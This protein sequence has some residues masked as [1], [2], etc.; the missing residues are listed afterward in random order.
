MMSCRAYNGR[1]ALPTRP[2]H[3]VAAA[4]QEVAKV[5]S[6]MPRAS[7]PP[8]QLMEMEHRA[9]QKLCKAREDQHPAITD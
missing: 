8:R 1:S 2:A 9:E 5:L 3:R 7:P 6:E 4:G